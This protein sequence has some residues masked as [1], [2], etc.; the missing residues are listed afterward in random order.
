MEKHRPHIVTPRDE[1]VRVAFAYKNL[2]ACKGISDIGLGVAGQH[3]L[4]VL[5]EEGIW[6]EVWPVNTAAD[7]ERRLAE[8]QAEA[9]HLGK[10]PISHVIIFAPWVPTNDLYQLVRYHTEVEFAVISHSN[11]GFLQAD[12]NGIRNLRD[13]MGL[14]MAVANFRLAGNCSRFTDWVKR[15]Y[16]APCLL[17]PNLYDTRQ[18][19]AMP[20]Q[21]GSGASGGTIRIG[22]FGAPRVQKNFISGVAAALEIATLLRRDTEIWISTGRPEGAV[23]LLN[24]IIQMVQGVKWVKLVQ[25]KWEPWPQFRHTIS[26]MDLLIQPSYTESFNIVTADGVAE[27]VPSVVSHAVDWAPARWKAE[28]DDVQDI[29]RVGIALLNDCH[30]AAEGMAALTHYVTHGVA[31]W[32]SYLFRDQHRQVYR[33]KH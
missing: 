18:A 10:T 12:P 23:T 25:N 7:I 28:V 6:I 1:K 29:A 11:V 20:R 8:S 27:G 14:E 2:A 21:P 17:L 16:N 4:K 13:E 26:H 9:F 33:V 24:A 22:C 30:S 3:T 19:H 15:A 5:Q 32:K 31:L